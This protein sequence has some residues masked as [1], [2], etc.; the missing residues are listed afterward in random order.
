MADF[1]EV[2]LLIAVSSFNRYTAQVDGIADLDVAHVMDDYYNLAS[3]TITAAGGRVVKFIGDAAFAVFARENVDRG[4]L[5]LSRRDVRAVTRSAL[6]GLCTVLLS[7]GGEGGDRIDLEVTDSAGVRLVQNLTRAPDTVALETPTVTI[8]GV[9]VPEPYVF[10]NVRDVVALSDG[11]IVVADAGGRVAVFEPDGTWRADIGR[12]GRGP[13]EYQ[14]PYRLDIRRDTLVLWDVNLARLSLFRP[15]GSFIG[16]VP[17]R[18]RSRATPFQWLGHL[19]V[20]EVEWGQTADPRPAEAVIL[21]LAV[22][23]PTDTLL[24]P[25]PV[26]EFGWEVEQGSQVGHMV[27][28]P[29]FS[30][31][32]AWRVCDTLLYW[33]D[34]AGGRV[35]VVTLA[36]RLRQVT[37]LAGQPRPVTQRDKDQHVTAMAERYDFSPE[38]VART[39]ERT[40]FAARAPRIT[41]LAC[42]ADGRVWL[43]DFQPAVPDPVDP[44]GNEWRV[45]ESDGREVRSVVFPRGF[46]LKS[47][48]GSRAYGVRSGELGVQL[49]EVYEVRPAMN[50]R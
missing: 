22:D 50:G 35:S 15:D 14:Q 20:D 8:G 38:A 25:Y 28:P 23:E 31:R 30:T 6:L 10:Q 17:V 39:R 11:S 48:A 29:V 37:S 4:V 32:P 46:I 18:K 12:R 36:G 2:P 3:S 13:G 33:A 19:L 44:V 41:G 45:I 7:C 26:P 1:S 9:K 24:G 21:R 43:A 42:D 49:V 5:C 47:L 27:M 40:E 16:T 34:P